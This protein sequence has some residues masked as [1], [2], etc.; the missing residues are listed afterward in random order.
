MQVA[1]QDKWTKLPKVGGS[2][3]VRTTG[4]AKSQVMDS[5][6][7]QPPLVHLITIYIPTCASVTAKPTLYSCPTTT[8]NLAGSGSLGVCSILQIS[9]YC[10]VY[11]R[12]VILIFFYDAR[13]AV[14]T[15]HG[16]FEEKDH[17]DGTRRAPNQ[18]LFH[19]AVKTPGF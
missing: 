9:Y 3:G 11:F 12:R 16:P 15:Y 5:D 4:N 8:N 6:L 13:V 17:I 7:I 1:G 19:P 18:T 14:Q 10:S 2:I